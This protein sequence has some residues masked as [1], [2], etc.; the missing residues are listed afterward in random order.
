MK[1]ILKN[2]FLVAL[3]SLASC[4]E[5]VEDINL[6]PNN[7]GVDEVAPSSF[8]TGILLA[9]SS[10]QVGH[11]NRIAGMWS[12]QYVGY[13]SLYS[14]IYGYNIS[15]AETDGTWNRVYIAIIPN[16][17]HIQTSAPNDNLLKGIAKNGG[18]AW[19]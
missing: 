10:A 6:N 8:L 3:I 15:A 2:I 14:N 16:G 4:T 18:G 13:T 9:N 19:Y 1:N 11:V 7:I 12:G 17:R 5:L